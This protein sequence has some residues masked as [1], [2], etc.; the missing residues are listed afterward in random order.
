[1]KCGMVPALRDGMIKKY[2]LKVGLIMENI[3]QR[4][5]SECQKNSGIDISDE[6]IQSEVNSVRKSSADNNGV[7]TG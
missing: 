5:L 2:P 6:E 4:F 3:V 1:M 7:F